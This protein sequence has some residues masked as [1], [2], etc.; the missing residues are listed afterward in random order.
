MTLAVDVK[1]L[2]SKGRV[3]RGD[4]NS[5]RMIASGLGGVGEGEEKGKMK[6][7]IKVG[8]SIQW[9][10]RSSTEAGGGRMSLLWDA[11]QEG[12]RGSLGYDLTIPR[13]II[14][15]GSSYETYRRFAH[16]L[17]GSTSRCSWRRKEGV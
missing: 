10:G 17:T 3:V 9:Y 5:L 11:Q 4:R 12:G 16:A 1:G 14:F 8:E 15:D 2:E 7:L 6:L 13:K